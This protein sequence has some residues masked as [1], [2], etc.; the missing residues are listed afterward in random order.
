M[1]EL[2]VKIA[3]RLEVEYIDKYVDEEFLRWIFD[4][5]VKLQET[6]E[7]VCNGFEYGGRSPFLL[8]IGGYNREEKKIQFFDMALAM[9]RNEVYNDMKV[10]DSKDIIATNILMVNTLLHELEHVNQEKKRK[11]D[12]TFEA[13][14]LNAEE[15]NQETVSSYD[16]MPSERFAENIATKGTLKILNNMAIIVPEI[17]DY[18]E[19][20]RHYYMIKGYIDEVNQCMV[21]PVKRYMNNHGKDFADMSLEEAIATYLDIEDR[22]FYGLPIFDDEYFMVREKTGLANARTSYSLW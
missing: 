1:D 12:D 17:Y 19:Q 21:Y 10:R 6:K 16:F 7:F 15:G 8:A 9:T 13:Y 4:E 5:V 11:N 2:Y 22:L 20:R 14:L 18:I 3:K